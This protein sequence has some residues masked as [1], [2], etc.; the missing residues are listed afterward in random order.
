MA[1]CPPIISPEC[2][3][4]NWSAR[5]KGV[6]TEI[7]GTDT[8]ALP[9]VLRAFGSK[10]GFAPGAAICLL[11][12]CKPGMLPYFNLSARASSGFRLFLLY[13]AAHSSLPL[14]LL[15]GGVPFLSFRFYDLPRPSCR[16]SHD[17]AADYLFLISV[18]LAFL[19][20]FEFQFLYIVLCHYDSQQS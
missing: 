18:L 12:E 13:S 5:P 14:C 11:C 10:G 19:G 1:K 3:G 15:L 17:G 6:D 4:V 20:L 2:R 8:Q 16:R 9:P 7:Y